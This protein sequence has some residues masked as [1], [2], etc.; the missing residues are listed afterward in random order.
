[1]CPIPTAGLKCP[2]SMIMTHVACEPVTSLPVQDYQV[3]SKHVCLSSKS[4]FLQEKVFCVW[5]VA[6]EVLERSDG[7]TRE[8]K[9]RRGLNTED[10]LHSLFPKTLYYSSPLSQ[11]KFAYIICFL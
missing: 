7:G 3:C 4:L 6:Q 11:N 10:P 9:D 1:M 2:G 5:C 8:F